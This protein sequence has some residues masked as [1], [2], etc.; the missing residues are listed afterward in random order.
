MTFTIEKTPLTGLLLV[1]PSVFGDERGY[2]FE[3]FHK[4]R[5]KEHGIDVEFIQDNI[6]KSQKNILRGLHFQNP[7][8]QGKL[9]SAL[10]GSIFDVAVDVRKDS[11]TFGK[12]YGIELTAENKFQLYVPRGFAHGFMVTSS[13]AICHY[14]CDEFYAPEHEFSLAW[15][16]P[17]LNID[18]PK[19]EPQLSKKDKEGRR[20]SEILSKDLPCV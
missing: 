13:E 5:Y 3:S 8:T 19:G 12:W 6:S 15:N 9:V 7:K 17:G 11:K 16:D 18:W 2:F 14:K 4:Q 10:L 20:L 1:K